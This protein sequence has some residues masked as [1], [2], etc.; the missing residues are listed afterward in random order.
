MTPH[1]H[2]M[3]GRIRADWLFY[4][5]VE[6]LSSC[7]RHL[8]GSIQGGTFSLHSFVSLMLTLLL[9]LSST[10]KGFTVPGR[11]FWASKRESWMNKNTLSLP[12][13]QS[14]LTFD[15]HI[16]YRVNFLALQDHF[17]AT[18]PMAVT[19]PCLPPFPTWDC[20]EIQLQNTTV[21]V[22]KSWREIRT[23]SLLICAMRAA[24]CSSRVEHL[25]L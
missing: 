19:V 20:K 23:W 15:I 10:A 21:N 12:N 24:F 7:Q 14:S 6:W 16:V 4:S 1:C 3:V 18:M 2:D 9:H 17:L 13:L 22:D 5:T 8:R 25:F 11:L